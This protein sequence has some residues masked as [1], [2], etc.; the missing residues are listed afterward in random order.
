MFLFI[1][2]SVKRGI[3]RVCA[4]EKLIATHL[5]VDDLILF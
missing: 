2:P 3:L 1:L 5:I 4:V